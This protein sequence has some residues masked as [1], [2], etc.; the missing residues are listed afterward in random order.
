M[1]I[2]AV[3]K[4]PGGLSV[5]LPVVMALRTANHNVLLFANGKAIELLEKTREVPYIPCTSASE[6]FGTY[7]SRMRPDV[8]ITSMCSGGGVG[9]DLV[10]MLAGVCP[11]IALQDYWG[12][13]L[14]TDWA[15]IKYRPDYICVNDTVAVRIVKK[16]WPDYDID[17]I[18]ITGNPSFD[19]FAVKPTDEE[20]QSIRTRLGIGE[21]D[22][23]VVYGGQL[24]H[25]GMMLAELIDEL[26]TRHTGAILIPRMHPRMA[27]NAP[28]EM[29]WWERAISQSRVRL[30][31]SDDFSTMDVTKIANVVVTMYS[32]LIAEAAFVGVPSIAMLYPRVMEKFRSE[33]GGLMEQVP[34]VELGCCYVASSHARLV[35]GLLHWCLLSQSLATAWYFHL[36]STGENT[37]NVVDLIT[38]STTHKNS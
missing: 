19:K 30:V 17:Q 4:D 22:F 5:I 18:K 27:V 29:Y 35:N 6:V 13:R 37:A 32:T 36:K 24:E 2:W 33:T 38:K 10:P 20:R 23:V 25:S 28:E 12:A 7:L 34:L 3:A 31:S 26:N 16:A 14:A 21:D 11:T 1:N 15:D 8:F 9:R